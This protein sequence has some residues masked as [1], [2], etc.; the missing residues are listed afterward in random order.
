MRQLTP[1]QINAARKR[2][3]KPPLNFKLLRQI[4]KKIE[5]AP[6]AYDQDVYGRKSDTAPCGTAACIAGWT[7]YLGNK[8]SM[9]TLQRG[10][11]VSFESYGTKLLGLHD[12]W[13][14][15]DESRL[16]TSNPEYNWPEPYA[17]QWGRAKTQR[18]QA[19]VA[20][21]YLTRIVR[22]GQVL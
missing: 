6:E 8:V 13:E 18:Q 15:E 10:S 12:S 1:R 20:I 2:E 22:T 5:T 16:F 14:S 17:T 4:I 7:C 9:R 21:R 3:G 19:R 11:G